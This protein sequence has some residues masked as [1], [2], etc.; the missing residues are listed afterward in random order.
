MRRAIAAPVYPKPKV[1]R[2]GKK[3]LLRGRSSRWGRAGKGE[4]V[5]LSLGEDRLRQRHLHIDVAPGDVGVGA[6]LMGGV[7]QRSS[8][9]EAKAGEADGQGQIKDAEPLPFKLAEDMRMTPE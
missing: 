7:D 8:G 3:E 6:E 4:I 9:L 5:V 1:S 2:L